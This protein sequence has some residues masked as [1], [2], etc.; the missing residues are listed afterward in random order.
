M[1][2]LL[3]RQQNS[4]MSEINAQTRSRLSQKSF[5]QTGPIIVRKI[6]KNLRVRLQAYA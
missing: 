3:R 2:T 4:M 6:S 1:E 5:R